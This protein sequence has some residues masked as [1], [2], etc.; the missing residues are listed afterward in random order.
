MVS[1]EPKKLFLILV[2]AHDTLL[3]E[4]VEFVEPPL[5]ANRVS[6]HL[7]LNEFKNSPS[8]HV[9]ELPDQR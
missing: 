9:P 6:L 3:Q 8:D 7:V 1:H 4:D 5:I 2:V